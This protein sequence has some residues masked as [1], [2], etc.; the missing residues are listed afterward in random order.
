MSY[1]QY[2]L[3]D[4]HFIRNIQNNGNKNVYHKRIHTCCLS[5]CRDTTRQQLK[6]STGAAQSDGEER[7]T[8]HVTTP[9]LKRLTHVRNGILPSRRSMAVSGERQ[10]FI[11]IWVFVCVCISICVRSLQNKDLRYE[12]FAVIQLRTR[13]K[14]A[15]GTTS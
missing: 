2:L 10:M 11:L 1:T 6:T 3:N 7:P 15:R 12:P 9:A 13:F 5:K 4:E 8:D 14:C